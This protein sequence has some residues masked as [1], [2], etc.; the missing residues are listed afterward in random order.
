MVVVDV[1][2]K[3]RVKITCF[4]FVGNHCK[5]TIHE[6]DGRDVDGDE[7]IVTYLITTFCICFLYTY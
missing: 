3:K 2:R 7:S 6:G 1:W 4:S 5:E